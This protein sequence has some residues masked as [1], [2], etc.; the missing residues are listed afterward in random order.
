MTKKNI[1]KNVNLINE[2]GKSEYI[3]KKLHKVHL[4]A[5]NL[6]HGTLDFNPKYWQTDT[7]KWDNGNKSVIIPNNYSHINRL[8]YVTL[9][10]KSDLISN[11]VSTK[12][13]SHDF[14]LINDITYIFSF[15]VYTKKSNEHSSVYYLDVGISY[16]ETETNLAYDKSYK[17]YYT[18]FQLNN[19]K[20][21]YTTINLKRTSKLENISMSLSY[22]GKDENDYIDAGQFFIQKPMLQ[23]SDFKTDYCPSTKDLINIATGR[24]DLNLN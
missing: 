16:R 6:L 23:I 21:L 3:S 5:E 13:N 24:Y 20:R 15:D 17:F 10:T 4:S 11:M 9:S 8:N 7:R 22:K 1:T 18:S 12:Y 14:Y 2:E 19:W